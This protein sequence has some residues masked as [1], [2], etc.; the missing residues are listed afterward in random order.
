MF[1]DFVSCA[2]LVEPALLQRIVR[3]ESGGNPLAIGVVGGRLARQPSNLQEAV[4]T[5]QAL[6]RSGWNYSIGAGQINRIHFSRFGWTDIRSGF[7]ACNNLAAAQQVLRECYERAVRHGYASAN[8]DSAYG[9]TH[10]SLSCYYSGDLVRGARLGYVKRV[11]G[12]ASQPPLPT[13]KGRAA[14][15]MFLQ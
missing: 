8:S 7:S 3:V 2:P 12:K 6:E 4:A 1:L 10:A 5:V 15:S 13:R 11:L 14:P 9:V